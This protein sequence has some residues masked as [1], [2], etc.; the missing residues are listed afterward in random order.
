MAAAIA[1]TLVASG[2]GAQQIDLSQGGAVVVTARGGFEWRENEQVVIA[3]VD[4]RAV[5]GDV[6]VLADRLIAH[7]RKKGTG[8]GGNAPAA[9]PASATTAATT[10]AAATPAA[11]TP[12]PAGA[13]GEPDS[14]GNEV[15]RLEAEDHV[16]IFT[17][18]DFAQGD[19]AIYDIDQAVLLMTGHNL[20]LTTPQDLMT[21][22][23]SMEYWSQRHIAVGRGNAVVVTNDGRRIAADVLVGYTTDP[24]EA[25]SGAQPSAPKPAAPTPAASGPPADPLLAAGKLKRVEAFGNVEVRTQTD[26]VYGDRGVYVPDTGMARVVGHV[27]ITRGQNQLN[28]PA[29]DVNMKTGIAHMISDPGQRVQGLIMPNDA[30]SAS[31]PAAGAASKPSSGAS[32]SPPAKP[33]AP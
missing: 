5:R 19:H 22:R 13:A 23:D 8:P 31:A 1:A 2:A 4:A 6:T 21:A 3:T 30:Q 12:A 14:G 18:T 20:K 28:G 16:R 26:I 17:P 24:N 25:P 7:Y 29:A 32:P 15:Y 9:T 27:R 11:T 10:T 33:P